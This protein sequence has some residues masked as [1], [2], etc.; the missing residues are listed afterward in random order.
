MS[1]MLS[2]KVKKIPSTAVSAD[3]YNFLKL[4]EA[5]PD[6][7]VPAANGYVLTSD[8]SGNR[9]W[10]NQS[11]P[12]SGTDIDQILT[13]TKTLTLTTDWQDTGIKS[14]DLTTGTYIIQLFA[15]D[16]GAGG[17]NN[18][19]YYSGTM[20]WYS[21]DTNSAVELPTDEIVLHRAGGSGDGALYLRTYR[22]PTAD[23]NNLKLQIYSNT[24]NASSANYVFKF[25]RII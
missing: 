12:S 14:N 20:S 11:A 4:S 18:N 25:R 6:L 21:A 15:N 19:E 3:R 5:E 24:A 10:V 7:G 9:I 8:T 2:G 16:T 22:T 1:N 23:I 17:T 13:L